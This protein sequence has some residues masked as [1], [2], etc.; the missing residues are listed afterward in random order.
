[1]RYQMH[2]CFCDNALQT[3]W[4]SRFVFERHHIP[5]F[6]GCFFFFGTVSVYRMPQTC[7]KHAHC[8]I[9]AWLVVMWVQMYRF[10]LASS[11]KDGITSRFLSFLCC[12]MSANQAWK[13]ASLAG[14]TY[15]RPA[16]N[17]SCSWG[18]R[19]MQAPPSA[20]ITMQHLDTGRPLIQ[21]RCDW[22]GIAEGEGGGDVRKRICPLKLMHSNCT[23]HNFWGTSPFSFS[24]ASKKTDSHVTSTVIFTS[25]FPAYL[26]ACQ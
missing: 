14:L 11:R 3:C 6:T 9:M 19:S 12:F 15:I 23:V 18:W 16:K 4:A 22:K 24:F 17:V 20:S 5:I 1:M 25:S 13:A 26:N 7:T 8:Q 2:H 10:S 21:L